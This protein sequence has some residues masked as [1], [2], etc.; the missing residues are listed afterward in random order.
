MVSFDGTAA[1]VVSLAELV[2]ARDPLN[3]RVGDVCRA[4][5]RAATAAPE[6][7]ALD[8]LARTSL[9]QGRGVVLVVRDHH[10]EGLIGPEDVAWALELTTAVPLGDREVTS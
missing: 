4:L 1:G 8:V 7:P 3:T 2:R 10:V 9:G 5:P 6:E